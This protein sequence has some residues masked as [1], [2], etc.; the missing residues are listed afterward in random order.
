M[1]PL[2]PMSGPW[3]YIDSPETVRLM[4]RT[5]RRAVWAWEFYDGVQDQYREDVPTDSMH[6]M[7][8][9]GRW[10]VSHKDAYNPDWSPRNIGLHFLFDILPTIGHGHG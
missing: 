6:L 9:N 7:V 4:G 3:P 8:T 2:C 10:R 5:F 1:T